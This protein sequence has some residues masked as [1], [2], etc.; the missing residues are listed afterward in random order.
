MTVLTER[1]SELPPS[2]A[3]GVPLPPAPA[4]GEALAVFRYWPRGLA[5][6]D[7]TW[8]RWLKEL[9]PSAKLLKEF[10]PRFKQGLTPALWQAFADRYR[11]EMGAPVPS[12]L[13]AELGRRHRAG[14][15]FTLLCSSVCDDDR[16]CHR[17][18]LRELVLA[19]A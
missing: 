14:D 15:T 8:D 4:V 19:S 18:L 7:V 5:K 12:G 17:T 2:H 11:A 16:Y 9:A 6:A 13:I 3:E 10:K 1:W